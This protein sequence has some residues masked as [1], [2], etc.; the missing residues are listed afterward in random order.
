MD[1]NWLWVDGRLDEQVNNKSGLKKRR[2]YVCMG[3][4]ERTDTEK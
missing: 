1:G 4:F 2:T 3:E